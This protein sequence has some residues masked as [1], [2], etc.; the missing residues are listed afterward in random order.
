MKTVLNDREKSLIGKID[1]KTAPIQAEIDVLT[2]EFQK[3]MAVLD[4]IK[5]K[6]RVKRPDLVPL[7]ELKA[8]VAS[9]N[10]RNKYFPEYL[11]RFDNKEKKEAFLKHAES[12]VG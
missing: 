5:D 1:A 10:S 11:G 4:K 2:A 6:L 8:G 9:I 3:Q 12:V 7:A